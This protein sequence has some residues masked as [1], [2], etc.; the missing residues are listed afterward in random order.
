MASPYLDLPPRS[1]PEVIHAKMLAVLN[2]HAAG[3]F[4]RVVWGDGKWAM[5]TAG[6]MIAVLRDETLAEPGK[7]EKLEFLLT[8]H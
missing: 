6:E 4:V 2:D 1:L 7:I 5:M 3:E 8:H